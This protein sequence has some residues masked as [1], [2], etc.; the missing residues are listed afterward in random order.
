MDAEFDRVD[1]SVE[2]LS[3]N[4]NRSIG[5]RVNQPHLPGI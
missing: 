4:F 3:D 5:E 1:V 2:E